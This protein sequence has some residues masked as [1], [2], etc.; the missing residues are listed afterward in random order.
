[1]I[2]TRQ[3]SLSSHDLSID[4]GCKLASEILDVGLPIILC[5]FV[6]ILLILVMEFKEDLFTWMSLIK[7]RNR[8]IWKMKFLSISSVLV[9]MYMY[10]YTST[11]CT[12]ELSS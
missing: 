11:E 10:I 3:E 8:K 12:T 4:V 2:E 9:Y 5:L 1:M 6:Q 7:T